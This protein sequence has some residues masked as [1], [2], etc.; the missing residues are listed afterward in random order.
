[1]GLPPSRSFEH[2]IDL[3]TGAEPVDGSIY[4]M[5]D[6]EF[7]ELKKQL[8]DLLDHGFNKPNLSPFGSPVVPSLLGGWL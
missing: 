5:S 3:V 7:K 4:R 6:H 1:M 8:E 2:R